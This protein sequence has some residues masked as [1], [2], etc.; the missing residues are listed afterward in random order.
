MAKGHC[1]VNGLQNLQANALFFFVPAFEYKI[2]SLMLYHLLKSTL[3][4]KENAFNIG[5]FIRFCSIT[6]GYRCFFWELSH[7]TNLKLLQ[8]TQSE[9]MV[10]SKNLRQIKEGRPDDRSAG[11]HAAPVAT[12]PSIYNILRWVAWTMGQTNGRP[13][14]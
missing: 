7:V 11:S 14:V 4:S 8:Q 10:S 2:Y 1:C 9:K 5:T 3:H 13:R 6:F 12:N